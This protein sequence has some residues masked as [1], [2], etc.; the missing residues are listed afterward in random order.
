MTGLSPA[1]RRMVALALLAVPP[2]LLWSLLLAPWLEARAGQVARLEAAEA[3][4]A[5]GLA[6]L[7]RE[8]AL[9]AEN[10][11]LRQ[12]LSGVA[13]LPAAGSHALAGAEWQRRLRE[14][15]RRHRAAVHSLETLPEERTGDGMI[16]LRGRLQADAEGLR[17]LLAEL[18]GGRAPLQVRG[19]TLAMGTAG[20]RLLEIQF[21]LR[22]PWA[23]EAR[24]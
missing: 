21:E 3:I 2:L 22:G 1:V 18:E 17:D 16:G 14:A 12:A 6:L 9:R 8:P 11:V 23:G 5:R 7:A 10:V 4:R 20:R 24:R 15:A 19:L 13:D